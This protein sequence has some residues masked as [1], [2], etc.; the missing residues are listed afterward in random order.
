M[1]FGKWFYATMIGPMT[2]SYERIIR[3]VRGEL[4]I[5]TVG[6]VV[7][8]GPGLGHNLMFLDSDVTWTGVEP[9]RFFHKRLHK[10]LAAKRIEG[11]VLECSAESVPL[12]DGCAD[13]VVC[14]LVL[15]SVPDPLAALKEAKRILKPNGKLVLIEH[16]AGPEGSRGRRSQERVRG[17][18][19]KLAGGCDVCR[20]TEK[21]LAP[22]GFSID[23][24]AVVRVPL[25]VIAP[26]LIAVAS[27]KKGKK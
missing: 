6:H 20:E 16:V 10:T 9:N 4:L 14:T 5:G 17:L 7:E 8:F 15:C 27:V 19:K 25:P 3:P 24:K 13:V 11:R 26:H 21:L 23:R 2:F 22:A 1:S 18:W 12:E